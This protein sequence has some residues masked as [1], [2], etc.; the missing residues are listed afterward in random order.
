MKSKTNDN[1]G[2]RYDL[3]SKQLGHC[4]LLETPRRKVEKDVDSHVSSLIIMISY[5]WVNGTVLHYCFMDERPEWRG[6]DEDKDVVRDSFRQWHELPIGISFREVY[7]P[8]EAEI[9]IGFERGTGSWSYVGRGAIDHQ[10][11]PTK[12]TMNF[13]WDLTTDYGRDT[14]LHEIG[15]ALGFP[16]SHQNPFSGIVWDEQ[17]VIQYFSGPPNWWDSAKIHHNILDKIPTSDVQGSAWDPNSIMH[18]QFEAGLILEPTKYQDE[19]LVPEAGLSATDIETVKRFYPAL[20]ESKYPELQPYLSQRL[21]G[22]PGDQFDFEIAPEISREYTLSTHGNNE[23]VMVLFEQRDGDLAYL[24]G[25]DDGGVDR[26][27]QIVERLEK[28]RKYVV[29]VRLYH[30]KV[31][32]DGAILLT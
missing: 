24:D 22:D 12:R 31:R 2:G 18:Y 5:K 19:P 17:A 26:N 9:R 11:D 32:G 23:L 28:G 16:H 20:E 8:L 27:A 30:Q 10:P 6:S 21:A 15:H 25:D 1:D 3:A 29:R 13:G 7:D 14:A 4:T